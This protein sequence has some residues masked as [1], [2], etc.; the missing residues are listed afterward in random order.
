MGASSLLFCIDGADGDFIDARRRE[1]AAPGIARLADGL[2]RIDIDNDPGVGDGPFWSAA[3]TGKD[4]S[5]H[6]RYFQVQFDPSTYDFYF[7][8]DATHFAGN[9][10]WETLDEEGLK[11]CVV[12]WPH[13]PFNPSRGGVLIDNWLQHDPATPARAWPAGYIDTVHERYMRDPL[14]PGL[15][16]R[17]LASVADMR[18]ILDH[19][20]ARIEAKAQFVCDRLA[21]ENWDLMAPTFSELHDLGHYL[22]HLHDPAH[23]A[24][25]PR[26]AAEIGDP[27]MAAWAATDRALAR[28]VDAAGPDC[29]VFVLSGLGM[30]SVA[31][32]NN[33]VEEIMRRLNAHMQPET[34]SVESARTAYRSLLPLWMR[35]ALSPLKRRIV[36][37]P[38]KAGLTRRKIFKIPHVEH[39]GAF[40]VNLAGRERYG[41]VQPGEEYDR[42]LAA[43]IENFREI[44][45]VDTG[46]SVVEKAVITRDVYDGPHRDT[47]P[48][49]FI[50]WRVGEPF[51]RVASPKIGEIDVPPILRTG[52]HTMKGVC[53]APPAR[54]AA[55]DGARA[56]RPGDLTALFLAAAR[57]RRTQPA[58]L[59]PA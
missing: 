12:D 54:L 6:K 53:W 2:A 21:E 49:L 4:A 44:R 11:T 46:E 19:A 18:R 28:V 9:A 43:L 27:L 16:A 52:D 55:L 7:F 22:Y 14:A 29:E 47:L 32:L 39:A 37:E 31:N 41:V 3:A 42:V 17:P 24:Y 36:P 25:N 57:A 35:K 13:G 10:F 15:H 23:R 26:A 40:R 45:D 1:G 48:D 38:P 8:D 50:H 56:A 51:R 34:A 33:V 59:A 58:E 5:H 30:R 20:L